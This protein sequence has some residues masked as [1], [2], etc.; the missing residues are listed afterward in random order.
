[1]MN[2]WKMLLEKQIADR[3]ADITEDA[4]DKGIEDFIF[5]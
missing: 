2:I 1:M 3:Q 4:N 5:G